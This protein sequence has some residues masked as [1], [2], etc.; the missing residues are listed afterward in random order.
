MPDKLTTRLRAEKCE[1][2]L[3]EDFFAVIISS[4][5]SVKSHVPPKDKSHLDRY[6]FIDGSGSHLSVVYDT[7]AAIITADAKREVIDR[8]ISVYPKL[9]ELNLKLTEKKEEN[10]KKEGEIKEK[11]PSRTKRK[12][13][14]AKKLIAKDELSAEKDST[15]KPAKS[16]KHEVA[17]PFVLQEVKQTRVDWAV[18]VLKDSGCKVR[19]SSSNQ[20]ETVYSVSNAAKEK[21]SIIFAVNGTLSVQGKKSSLFDSLVSQFT[22]KYDRKLM[23]KYFPV[24]MAYLSEASLIDLYN[25]LSDIEKVQGLSDYSFLLIGPYRALEKFIFD[26]QK[27]KNI[28]VKMIGQAYDKDKEGNYILKRSYQKRIGSVVYAEIMVSL[29]IEYFKTRNYYTHSENSALDLS[30]SIP[31]KVEAKK[32]I[33]NLISIIEYNCRKLKEIGFTL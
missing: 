15:K 13:K 19:S 33:M 26:L 27:A 20:G 17:K 32:I 24:G 7:K 6:H 29:Y 18:K 3:A 28:S 1:P 10:P 2:L 16:S 8:I 11:K 22:E 12:G 25:G 23:K 9:N 31:D 21:A 30:R 14:K 5:F 4:G